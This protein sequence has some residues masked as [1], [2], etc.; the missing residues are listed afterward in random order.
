MKVEFIALFVSFLVIVIIF[1][2][3]YSNL[4][5]EIIK[6][7]NELKT[8]DRLVANEKWIRTYCISNKLEACASLQPVKENK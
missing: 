4:S 5:K 6:I 1:Y 7:K 8:H 3:G 2:A